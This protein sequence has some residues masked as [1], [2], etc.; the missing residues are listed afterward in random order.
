M[1][2]NWVPKAAANESVALNLALRQSVAE[3]TIEQLFLANSFPANGVASSAARFDMA[4]ASGAAVQVIHPK[5]AAALKALK[6]AEADAKDLAAAE[7]SNQLIV[8]TAATPDEPP[9]WWTVSPSGTAVARS[10]GG[11]G[12]AET[13]YAELTLNVACKILCFI[14]MLNSGKST[15][16][17]VSF[18]LCAGMQA[19]GGAAEMIAEDIEFEGMGFIVAA[20]D[21]TIWAVMGMTEPKE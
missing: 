21:L 13:D 2:L 10:Q 9:S 20:I 14:E 1:G 16:A 19:G 3:S 15:R 5:D 18:L 4:R 6:W 11:F 12:E 7:P 8:A 17:F